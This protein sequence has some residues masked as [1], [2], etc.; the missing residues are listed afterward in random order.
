MAVSADELLRTLEANVNTLLVRC[1]TLQKEVT[2]LKS[3]NDRQRQEMIRTHEE[4]VALQREYKTL[5]MAHALVSGENREMARRRLTQLIR[6]V[7]RAIE[8]V[9]SE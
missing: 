7:D 4:L 1:E 3:D 9:K 5:E 8:I 2:Q 6:Q